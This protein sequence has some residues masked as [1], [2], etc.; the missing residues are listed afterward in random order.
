MNQENNDL[1]RESNETAISQT[2]NWV[3]KIV[4]KHN[5]CPFAAKPFRKDTIRYAI[6][7]AENENDLVD[8]LVNEL[9][10]I[11]DAKSEELETTI[12]ILASCLSDFEDYNQFLDVVDAILEE[13]DLVGEIQMASFHPDYCFADLTPDDVRNYTNR[14]IYPMFHLIRE[15][16]VEAARD[17]YPDVDLVPEKNMTLLEKIGL[18]E[19]LKEISE[20]K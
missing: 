6:S 11:R 18:E 9:A 7:N 2:K 1:I 19:I 10:K 13:M 17:S 5:F 4:I 16:S 15:A 8:D 3:E 12:L 20:I 14:S